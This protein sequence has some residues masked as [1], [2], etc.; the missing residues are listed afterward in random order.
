MRGE[1]TY[2]EVRLHKLG[3]GL[4]NAF[5]F[6]EVFTDH[7]SMSID[8]DFDDLTVSESRISLRRSADPASKIQYLHSGFMFRV[9]AM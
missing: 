3:N 1:S 2:H 4:T 5:F 7:D 9:F 6:R 8:I